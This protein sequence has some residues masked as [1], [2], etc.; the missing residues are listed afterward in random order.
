MQNFPR[1]FNERG[2]TLIE[3][4]IAAG[5]LA[6][7]SYAIYQA[8]SRAFSLTARMSREATDMVALTLSLQTFETDINQIY[9]PLLEPQASQN[10]DPSAF[11]SEPVRTDGLR[12]SRFQG[13]KERISFINNGHR[14]IE[15]D[16]PQ[17]E[18]QK[19]VWEVERSEKGG[20]TLYRST[21]WDAFSTEEPKVK[22]QRVALLEN[23]S[24]VK[25]SYYRL[26]TKTWEDQW[27]SESSFARTHARYPELISLKIEVPDPENTNIQIPIEVKVR[28]HLALNFGKAD[29]SGNQNPGDSPPPSPSGAP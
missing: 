16:S 8:N 4:L 3:V 17:S 11:W 10:K 5:L 24:S 23:I 9:T 22:P 2:L 21:D 1:V 12:R 20:F 19:V 14:R 29:I 13:G 6:M 28:P 18:F 27:D 7:L 26:E 15:Q 25:F